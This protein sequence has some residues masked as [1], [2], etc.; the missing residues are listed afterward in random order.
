LQIK[1]PEPYI[2]E[3]DDDLGR[4]PDGIQRTLTDEQ[5]AMFRHSEIQTLLRERRH[6]E[7]AAAD[8]QEDEEVLE[9]S[10]PRAHRLEPSNREEDQRPSRSRKG[11]KQKKSQRPMTQRRHAR[12]Q[13]EIAQ[14][15]IQLEY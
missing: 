3:E 7:E 4:Y 6:R 11:K 8:E 14:E 1:Q 9:T 12:E 10:N 15:N 2:S 5:I 13:D